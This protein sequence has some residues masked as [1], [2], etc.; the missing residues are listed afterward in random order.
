M[1]QFTIRG[2]S[3]IAAATLL[4]AF[5]STV[6]LH[7]GRAQQAAAPPHTMPAHAKPSADRSEARIKELHDKLQIT[8][9]QEAQW[10]NVAQI[11]RENGAT[12]RA[13]VTD[14]STRLKTMNAIEDLKS[15]QAI[16]DQQ[17]N[18]L[19][20][21]IPAFEALYADMT[22][23]QQKRADHVFGEHERHARG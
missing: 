13:S 23:A 5:L 1:S 6:P 7:E 17:S 11:M 12:F 3:A 19:K 15:F 18:G 16:A 22:P 9:A 2:G 10:G 20:R 4:G 8:A 14:R 21:L